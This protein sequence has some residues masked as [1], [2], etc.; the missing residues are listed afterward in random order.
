VS[1]ERP[2]LKFAAF[3]AVCVAFA[4]WLIVTIGNVELFAD[5]VGYEATMG[6]ITGL[7]VNDAVKVAGV[8]VGKVTD[9]R[10]ERG[11]AVVTFSV[12]DD[13][14]LGED[15]TVGVRWRNL[16]GLRYVYVYPAGEGQLEPGHRFPLERTI[17]VADF[18]R[19]MERLVPIQRSLEP[20]VGNVVVRALN[21]AL[22]GREERVQRLIA[23][24]GSLTATLADRDQQIGRVLRNGARLARA[25][26]EREEALRSFLDDFAD[27]SETVAARN[28][29]IERIIVDL[30]DA[31][32]ELSRF[33]EANDDAIRG[34]VDG[35]DE[36]TAVLSV[37]HSN[38]EDLVTHL[39]R[40]LAFYHRTSRWGQWFN[41]RVAGASEGGE[42]QPGVTTERGACL[43]D[44]VPPEQQEPGGGGADN[45][46][47]GGRGGG[48]AGSSGGSGTGGAAGKRRSTA[49]DGGIGGI[50]GGG[51]QARSNGMDGFLRAGLRRSLADA[52]Q[53]DG[54]ER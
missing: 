32:Q 44:R 38:L 33:L 31:Q 23:E 16:L 49:D 6:D 37:N 47:A 10:V 13:V 29:E 54:G 51:G 11:Q 35:L 50:I 27:V 8:P 25:Y 4:A 39:G 36:I 46:E 45:C 20:E 53:A 17:A 24:A 42:Y 40:G 1:G 5:R 3:A 18:A 43:P 14:R 41:V 28:D 2:L 12:D 30:A 15:T 52:V 7:V 22:V 48:D 19:L 21:D 34:A 9:I 26:A